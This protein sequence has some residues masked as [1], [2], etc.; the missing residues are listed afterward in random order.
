MLSPLSLPQPPFYVTSCSF[1]GQGEAFPSIALITAEALKSW[2]H[3][4]PCL[5][6][7]NSPYEWE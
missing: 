5:G 4:G 7:D 3:N 2:Q 1:L 6:L